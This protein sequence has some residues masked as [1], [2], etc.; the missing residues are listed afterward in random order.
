MPDTDSLSLLTEIIRQGRGVL[1][2]GK[3]LHRK[4][5]VHGAS[6]ELVVLP[7]E[8]IDRLRLEVDYGPD[9]LDLGDHADWAEARV[10]K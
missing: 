4:D 8:G 9:G 10:T 3:E 2:D 1:A 7:V 6:P 5:M